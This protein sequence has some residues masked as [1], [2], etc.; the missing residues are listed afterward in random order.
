M[1]KQNTINLEKQIMAKVKSGQV[2]MKSRLNILAQKLG[3]G[4]GVLLLGLVLIL[5][6]AGLAYWL[7]ANS[8][9]YYLAG[10]FRGRQI[11]W[12]TFPYLWL[13]G[14]IGLFIFLS[15]LLKKYD[16]SYKKPL[17]AILALILAL[18]LTS[19]YLLQSHP[20][21]ANYLRKHLPLIYAPKTNDFGFVIG[22]VLEKN[23]RQLILNTQG[24]QEYTVTYNQQTRFPKGTIEVGD[25]V[26]AMGQINEQQ[27][28][29][30][31]IMNLSHRR[32][33]FKITPSQKQY[34]F[35]NQPETRPQPRFQFKKQ[36]YPNN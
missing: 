33:M 24:N 27:L 34:H 17:L 26:R 7:R 8:D 1:S 23:N 25:T 9:L 20:T 19:G 36:T 2:K 5:I 29:A 31:A 13:A 3:L 28:K 14:F 18:F 35:Q 30:I 6:L 12:Q 21:L 11:F 15:W 32:Q 10:P 16:F 22:E 4:S